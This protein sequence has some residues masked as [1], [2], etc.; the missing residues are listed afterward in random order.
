[1]Q[2]MNPAFEHWLKQ[3]RLSIDGEAFATLSSHLLPVRQHGV[4]AM[5]KLSHEAEEKRGHLLMQWWNGDGAARV[6]A[7]ESDALLLERAQGPASLKQMVHAGQDDEATR[8]LCA[9]AARLHA[10]RRPPPPGL[11]ELPQWFASLWPA[12]D[13]LGGVFAHSARTAHELLAAPR[14]VTALHGDIHHGNV[15]DFG[16]RGWLAIDPKCLYGERGFDH[17]NIFCNPDGESALAPGRF[18]RRVEVVVQATGI[19]RQRL[20]QWVLAWASLSA[21]WMLEDGE[22][23]GETLEVAKLATSALG[24]AV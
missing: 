18:A 8:I 13:S 14:D 3:W 5:L 21:A 17:A 24:L 16:P 15:L 9:T 19:E 22:A 1:M 4:P 6:L 20:L 11:I 12:G 7:H 23:P 10:P 2:A